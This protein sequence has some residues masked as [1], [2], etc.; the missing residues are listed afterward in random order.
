MTMRVCE[1]D[2]VLRLVDCGQL[3]I[4][5]SHGRVLDPAFV[6]DQVRLSLTIGTVYRV[7]P[8][9]AVDV[10]RGET[11]I[12]TEVRLEEVT[13]RPGEFYLALT[14]EW[15]RLGP[16]LMATI[17]TRSK[18]ARLGLDFCGSSNVIVPGFGT[19][20]AAPIV[21]EITAKLPVS[22]LSLDTVFC[23][24]LL[25]ELERAFGEN[26]KDYLSRF[27]LSDPVSRTDG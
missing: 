24:L 7:D 26:S 27:P 17:H 21:L 1:R 20:G 5:D 12:L 13:L 8:N 6:D 10:S 22:G 19:T 16:Q 15:L 9:R 2:E 18:W 23:F 11:P 14:K 4:S 25:F 3:G